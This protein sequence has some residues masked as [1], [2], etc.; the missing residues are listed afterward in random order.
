MPSGSQRVVIV[1]HGATEWSKS[2]QHTG[3][4]DLPLLPEGLRDAERLAP[5]LSA[6]EFA[7]VLSSPLRR[8]L[9]TCRLAGLGEQAQIDENLREWNYG[10]YEG[11]STPAIRESRPDWDLWRDGCPGGETPWEVQARA[12]RVLARCLTADGDVALFAHGHILRVV[13]ARWLEL[14]VEGGARFRLEPAAAG[15]LG[16]ER[17]TRVLLSWNLSV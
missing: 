17:E 5:L 12:D 10:D 9:D 4:T 6:T 8:A 1:R 3:A 14:P 11:L 7:L 2:G 13:C 15:Q 16:Y